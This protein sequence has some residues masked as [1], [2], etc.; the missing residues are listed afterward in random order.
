VRIIKFR[1]KTISG[2]WAY[3]SLTYLKEDSG[4]IQAGYYISNSA[5]MPFA[6]Q[7]REETIGQHTGF[8]DKNN[9][10][11]WEGDIL[12][13]DDKE[14]GCDYFSAVLWDIV[15]G[16]WDWGGGTTAD[17]GVWRSVAGNI[18]ENID[19]LEVKGE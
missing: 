17:I 16:A 5:G 12:D 8:K 13:F 1:G 3:G 9:K 7:V 14:W 15:K 11:I 18:Y 19:L 2:A 10:D 6:Y 4:S